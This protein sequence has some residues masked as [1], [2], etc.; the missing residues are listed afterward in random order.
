MLGF[1]VGERGLVGRAVGWRGGPVRFNV[2]G[3]RLCDGNVGDGTRAHVGGGLKFVDV[4]GEA[5][6]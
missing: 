4:A 1:V 6:R 3:G 2:L 5:R